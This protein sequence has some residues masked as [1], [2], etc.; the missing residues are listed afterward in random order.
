[1]PGTAYA[2]NGST[3][4]S[5]NE[6]VTVSNLDFEHDNPLQGVGGGECKGFF[7]KMVRKFTFIKVSLYFIFPRSERSRDSL[8]IYKS[9]KS[10]SIGV[11]IE[12]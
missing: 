3:T 10:G 11:S 1:M 6:M 12:I 5:T 8:Q 7:S 4:R 9:T 2:R